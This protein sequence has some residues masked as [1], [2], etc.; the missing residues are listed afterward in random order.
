MNL[1]KKIL[2]TNKDKMRGFIEKSKA[3]FLRGSTFYAVISLVLVSVSLFTYVCSSSVEKNNLTEKNAS[4]SSDIT[5]LNSEVQGNNALIEEQEG[6]IKKQ[7]KVIKEQSESIEKIEAE[8]KEEI[9]KITSENEKNNEILNEIMDAIGTESTSRSG[10]SMNDRIDKIDA[11]S[12]IIKTKL[13][14]NEETSEYLKYLEKLKDEVAEKAEYYPDYDPL[15]SGTLT[16][17]FGYRTDP[18]GNGTK[19]HS[20]IDV[21]N[22]C[23]TPIFSAASG[24]VIYSDDSG[25]FGLLV[26]IDHGNGYKT[27]YAHCSSLHVSE[28]DVV[29]KG[30]LIAKIGATGNATGNHLH[31]EIRLDDVNVNPLDYVFPEFS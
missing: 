9:D 20:G 22:D 19:Y 13:G 25:E 11:V 3:V 1:L 4:L 26:I 30:Q 31:F 23:G 16:S 17:R 18:N 10:G 28:G 21:W 6:I 7:E 5:S 29:S 15:E 24:T 8:H 27:V 14:E 2:K 12:Y